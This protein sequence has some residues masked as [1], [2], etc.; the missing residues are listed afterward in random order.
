MSRTEKN[1]AKACTEVTGKPGPLSS[2]QRG[3]TG[4]DM[5]R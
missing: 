3:E 1:D 4:L 2:P 5:I